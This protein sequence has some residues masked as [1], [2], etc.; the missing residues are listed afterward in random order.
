MTFNKL[1]SIFVATCSLFANYSN[2][3]VNI[4]V[5]SN[6]EYLVECNGQS[7]SF[8][9]TTELYNGLNNFTGNYFRVNSINLDAEHINT[10]VFNGIY[11]TSPCILLIKGN[12]EVKPNIN[13]YFS[14]H[15]NFNEIIGRDFSSFSFIPN[16]NIHC[17]M[18]NVLATSD[19]D[20]Q[21]VTTVE[22]L[23]NHGTIKFLV[24]DAD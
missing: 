21:H 11:N 18:R 12:A 14:N 9:N 24:L 13:L 1:L 15:A 19:T 23:I 16:N 6:G 8:K 20:P 4:E 5:K 17:I 3:Q 2:A 10:V 7:K 22:T